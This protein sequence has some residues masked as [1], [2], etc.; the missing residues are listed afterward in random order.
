MQRSPLSTVASVNTVEPEVKD[1]QQRSPHVQ[2]VSAKTANARQRS[3]ERKELQTNQYQSGMN[4]Y[5]SDK[6]N[7]S[8]DAVSSMSPLAV[9]SDRVNF[10]TAGEL[11]PTSGLYR[12]SEESLVP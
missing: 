8:E 5:R 3:Q 10:F 1:F 6:T 12:S 7:K 9:Q 11:R 2:M 4:Q